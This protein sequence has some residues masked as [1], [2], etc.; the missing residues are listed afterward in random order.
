MEFIIVVLIGLLWI[1]GVMVTTYGVYLSFTNKW[2]FGILSLLIPG[3][4]FIVGL[5]KLFANKNIWEA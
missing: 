4:A 3:V 2:Y 1:F 5:F